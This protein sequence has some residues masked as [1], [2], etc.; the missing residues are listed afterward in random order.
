MG[1]HQRMAGQEG[2]WLLNRKVHI[3]NGGP[4]SGL[5]QG[6]F[7]LSTREQGNGCGSLQAA[8][9]VWQCLNSN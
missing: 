9:G 6:R 5:L 7:Y 4:I 2:G 8:Q 3:A 1:A